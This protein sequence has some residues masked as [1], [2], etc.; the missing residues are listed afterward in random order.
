MTNI[1][2]PFICTGSNS[3]DDHPSKATPIIDRV[4][5]THSRAIAEDDLHLSSVDRNRSKHPM[6]YVVHYYGLTHHY[7]SVCALIPKL[8]PS[9]LSGKISRLVTLT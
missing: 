4:V 1:H 2:L 7:I 9:A 8:N 3:K 6:A 5:N